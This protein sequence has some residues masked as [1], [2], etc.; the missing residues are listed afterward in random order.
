[1]VSLGRPEQLV[2]KFCPP[3]G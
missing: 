3:H 2:C 1:M